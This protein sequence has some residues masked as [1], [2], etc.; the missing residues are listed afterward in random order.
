MQLVT[1]LPKQAPWSPRARART[2]KNAPVLV[3]VVILVVLLVVYW[4]VDSTALTSSSLSSLA[5]AGTGLGLAA[6][7]EAVIVLA[8]GL[9]LSVGSI[10]SLLNVVLVSQMTGSGASQTGLALEVLG[11][12]VATSAINGLLVLGLQLPSL[13]VTLSMSFLWQGVALLVMAQPSGTVPFGFT[14]ALSGSS[15]LGIPN[16]VYLIL[17]TMIIWSLA[18]RTSWMRS[19]YVL[20]SSTHTAQANGIP[21]ARTTIGAYAFAGLFY[22]GAALLLTAVSGSGDPTLGSPLLITTFA[23]VVLGGTALGGGR[24]DAAAAL[25]GAFIV[26]VIG[27]VLFAL[28]V[29]AFYT[30]VF[31]GAILLVAVIV[32]AVMS[33]GRSFLRTLRSPR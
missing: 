18:K 15:F 25:L 8:G 10:L 16:A 22:G 27:D 29:S 33:K 4:S 7:G 24:G 1:R 31:N 20:G 6:V 23:A 3:A 14:S 26:T 9:D 28:Q 11:I 32:G 21:I 17:V 13:L 2:A 12:G 19:V 30:D 5:D